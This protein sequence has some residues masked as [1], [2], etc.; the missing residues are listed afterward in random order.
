MNWEAMLVCGAKRAMGNS[1][2]DRPL[3][4]TSIG[5]NPWV[6]GWADMLDLVNSH[7]QVPGASLTPPDFRL[8]GFSVEDT[9]SLKSLKDNPNKPEDSEAMPDFANSHAQVPSPPLRR[10]SSSGSP[11][12]SSRS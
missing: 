8:M 5:R 12:P 11:R 7:A 10:S 1:S 9:K 4:D 6:D 2:D 3:D